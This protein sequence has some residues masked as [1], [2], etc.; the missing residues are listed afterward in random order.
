M[1]SLKKHLPWQV[2]IAAKIVLSRLS[3]GYRIWQR[4]GLFKHGQMEDP[5]YALSCYETHYKRVS[6]SRKGNGFVCLELG[7]GDSLFSAL[8]T[9][10]FGGSASYL[11]DVGPFAVTDVERYRRMSELLRQKGLPVTDTYAWSRINDYLMACQARYLTEGVCSLKDIP[12][13]SVDF[14]WS[15]AVLEHIRKCDFFLMLRELRRIIRPDGV[16]SHR[17]DL[18]DHLSGALNNLRFSD[19]TWESE[20]FSSSGFYTNRI[21]FS[22]MLGLFRDSGFSVEIV[23]VDRWN[24]LPTPHAAL[25]SEF[26]QLSDEELRVSVFDVILRPIH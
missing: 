14:I 24:A 9:R 1:P 17:V 12:N 11:V 3:T 16:C 19:R 13:A 4:I 2:K 10:A 7:P 8:I 22:E 26:S 25:A 15:N 20:F 23:D 21:R 6:F 5:S 18:R